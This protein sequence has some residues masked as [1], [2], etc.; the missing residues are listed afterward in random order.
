[1][2]VLVFVLVLRYVSMLSAVVWCGVVWLGWLVGFYIGWC[3][4][5]YYGVYYEEI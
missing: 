4:I 2:F 3:S 1:M 5:E